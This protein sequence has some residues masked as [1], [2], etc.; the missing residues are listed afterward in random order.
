[1]PTVSYTFSNTAPSAVASTSMSPSNTAP[2]AVAL[3][4]TAGTAS[5]PSAVAFSMAH[6][7]GL[8]VAVPRTSQTPANTA[9]GIVALASMAGTAAEP[10]AVALTSTTPS[11]E[12]P[13]PIEFALTLAQLTDENVNTPILKIE[14]ALVLNSIYGQTRIPVAS[15]IERVQIAL[16][17]PP[18]GGP[19]TITLVD[20]AGVTHGVSITVA[21]GATFAE[22]VLP[23]ALAMLAGTNIR[24][25]CTATP[26]GA[27]PG[28]FGVVTLF[29][30][31]GA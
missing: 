2:S 24:A 1:M 7:N 16:E 18:A 11:N 8:P 21:D 19:V 17:S 4:S 23:V 5:A 28:G 20:A 31:L 6:N 15:A 22:Y 26:G 13:R 3:A 25:K 9:P 27:D 12:A 29:T 10:G 30:R 14:G